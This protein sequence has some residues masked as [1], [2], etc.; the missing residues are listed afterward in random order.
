MKGVRVYFPAASRNSL[1]QGALI[2]AAHAEYNKTRKSRNKRERERGRERERERGGNGKSRKAGAI[3]SAFFLHLAIFPRG[4]GAG[5]SE[6]AVNRFPGNDIAVGSNLAIYRMLG[7]SNVEGR[8]PARKTGSPE[9][10]GGRERDDAQGS[11]LSTFLLYSAVTLFPQEA[12]S[13]RD[14]EG[15]GGGSVRR[16]RERIRTAVPGLNLVSLI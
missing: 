5:I 3:S 13:S 1:A 12:P 9:S 14:R 2:R 6:S 16:D 11:F 10:G 4:A 7:K 15:R 8:Q